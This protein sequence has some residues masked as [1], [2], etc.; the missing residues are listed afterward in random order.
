MWDGKEVWLAIKG[1]TIVSLLK[2][3]MGVWELILVFSQKIIF[4]A[5][6]F[7]QYTDMALDN[8]E[9]HNEKLFSFLFHFL[10][11]CQRKAQFGASL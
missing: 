8:M 10:W 11:F 5:D 4:I 6:I 7:R 3:T 1:V 9:S 2:R